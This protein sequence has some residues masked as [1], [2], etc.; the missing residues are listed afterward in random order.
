MNFTNDKGQIV[1][2]LEKETYKKSVQGSKHLMRMFGGSWGIEEKIV[3]EIKNRCS[4]IEVSD[5]ESGLVYR[6][7]MDRF[8]EK[9]IVKDFG[10]RQRFLSLKYWETNTDNKLF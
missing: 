1:G 6:V 2:V 4:K 7:P 3:Q 8:I 5:K 9:G 10:T